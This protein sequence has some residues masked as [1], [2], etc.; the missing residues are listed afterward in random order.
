MTSTF[1][2]ARQSFAYL[3][4]TP[5]VAHADAIMDF[6]EKGNGDAFTLNQAI[7]ACGVA[8]LQQVM[9]TLTHLTQGAAP[10]LDLKVV[11]VDKE[12]IEHLVEGD[13]LG[14]GNGHPFH[15]PI[16]GELVSDPTSMMHLRFEPVP[17]LVGAPPTT[18]SP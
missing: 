8:D 6:V 12:G 9:A 2:E 15:H 13:V 3:A 17:G 16:S 5:L 14:Y 11:F 4:G 1:A 7:D 10:V 18:G